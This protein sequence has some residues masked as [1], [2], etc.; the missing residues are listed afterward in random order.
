MEVRLQMRPQTLLEYTWVDE[1]LTIEAAKETRTVQQ[2]AALMNKTAQQVN[3]ATSSLNEARLYLAWLGHHDAYQL[4]QKK[5]QF[6]QDLAKALRNKTS[7][8]IDAAR[9]IAWTLETSND[10]S[11][12]V[13]SYN[14]V[15]SEKVAEVVKRAS[16]QLGGFEE[17]AESPDNDDFE[18]SFGDEPSSELT[19]FASAMDDESTRSLVQQTVEAIAQ[20]MVTEKANA[21]SAANPL[22]LVRNARSALESVTIAKAA[23]ATVAQ[24]VA[25]LTQIHQIAA[26]LLEVA[27]KVDQAEAS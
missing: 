21:A 4:V 10:R 11:G 26:E 24:I 5:Q 13:Y 19:S 12:R 1:A 16:E 9:R 17:V 20:D 6:F 25:Q 18:I 7:E 15:F 22:K 3:L 8:E 2:V 23:P 14:F 27:E